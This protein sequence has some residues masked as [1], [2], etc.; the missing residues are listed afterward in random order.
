MINRPSEKEEEFFK[1]K[2]MERL[3]RLSRE[4][5]EQLKTQEREDEKKRHWMKCPKCGM[6][7][8]E[9][10]FRKI[11][12]DKCF[13]CEGVYL[14]RGELDALLKTEDMNLMK[15]IARVFAG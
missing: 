3:R 4:K 11:K 1:R 6:D 15:K 7:L 10:E 14:D 12:V 13:S 9:V 5:E 8:T 2:E